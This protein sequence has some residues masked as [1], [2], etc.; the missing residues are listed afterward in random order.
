MRPTGV[1]CRKS[2][3][4]VMLVTQEWRYNHCTT[5]LYNSDY[6]IIRNTTSEASA[7]E[8]RQ[9]VMRRGAERRATSEG[10]PSANYYVSLRA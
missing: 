3:E 4:R 2:N 10:Q 9:E 8:Y 1:S 5:T 6:L 7:S